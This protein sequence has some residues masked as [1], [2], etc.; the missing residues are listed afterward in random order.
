MQVKVRGIVPHIEIEF[1]NRFVGTYA[2]NERRVHR[3]FADK[4]RTLVKHTPFIEDATAM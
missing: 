2:E 4:A 1:I 3:N